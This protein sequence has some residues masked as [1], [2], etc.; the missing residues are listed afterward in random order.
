VP[1]IERYRMPFRAKQLD[2]GFDDDIFASPLLVSVVNNQHSRE[3]VR[4][5]RLQGQLI[6]CGLR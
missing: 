2:F 3:V 1:R 6:V 4:W 5:I